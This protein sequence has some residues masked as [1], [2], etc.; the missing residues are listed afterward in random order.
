[1]TPVKDDA[2]ILI[3]EDD[4]NIADLVEMYLRREGFQVHRGGNGERAPR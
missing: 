2:A 3:I 1:M 4:P